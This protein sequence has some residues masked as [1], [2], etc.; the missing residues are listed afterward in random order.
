MKTVFISYRRS[1]SQW[2]TRRINESLQRFLPPKNIFMDVDSVAPGVNFL[3]VV[4][5]EIAKCDL[6]LVVIG[7]EW[8]EE[9]DPKTGKNRLFNP[10]DY[11]RNEISAAL[12]RNIPVVPILIDGTEMPSTKDLP[13]ELHELS[14]RNASFLTDRNFDLDIDNL[15]QKLGMSER[16]VR[17]EGSWKLIAGGMVLG[18]IALCLFLSY[19]WSDGGDVNLDA[20]SN[21]TISDTSSI[22]NSSIQNPTFDQ[23]TG[24]NVNGATLKTGRYG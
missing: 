24:Y 4:S 8:I 17:R 15:A 16:R 18:I 12:E 19:S 11:V 22:D 7:P 3:D 13:K 2:A 9:I 21:G 5:S 10:E 23:I 20:A 6:L 14:Q 1:D